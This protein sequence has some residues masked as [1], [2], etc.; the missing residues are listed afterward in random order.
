MAKIKL[1]RF[2]IET[3]LLPRT[4]MACGAPADNFV[5]KTFFWHPGWVAV[6]IL[7]GL[8][9][10]I[11]VALI[12]TKRMKIPVPLCPRHRKY[13]LRRSL[14]V[15]LGL[16]VIIMAAIGI[17][18][19]MSN[20]KPGGGNSDDF[21]GFAIAGTGGLFLLWLITAA[22]LQRNSIRATEI[23]PQ[24]ITL[25]NVSSDF[26]SALMDVRRSYGDKDSDERRGTAPPAERYD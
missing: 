9:P 15:G 17:I 10:Y 8:W 11:I 20:K 16:V 25:G 1:G 14:F 6:L 7:I 12:L 5:R 19:M 2:E 23:T 3:G 4:C 26:K 13:F 22:V 21:L 24:S 18:A